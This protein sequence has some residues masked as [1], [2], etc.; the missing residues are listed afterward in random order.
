M[1]ASRIMMKLLSVLC[2]AAVFIPTTVLAAEQIHLSL[3]ADAS[4]MI[5]TWVSQQ[6]LPA[7]L[8]PA[9]WLHERRSRSARTLTGSS[10][11]IRVGKRL[12]RE[13]SVHRVTL[14][15]LT[16]DSEYCES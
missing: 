1:H 9:V 4:Q 15:G 5:V 8:L 16:P 12:E 3:G 6:R 2:L 10:T 13:I 7:A 14:S 11:R